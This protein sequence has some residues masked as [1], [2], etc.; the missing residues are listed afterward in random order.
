MLFT[1]DPA[2]TRERL[3]HAAHVPGSSEI[4]VPRE[5]LNVR[6]IPLP[7]TAKVNYVGLKE[8]AYRA[9]AAASGA[10]QAGEKQTGRFSRAD[11]YSIHDVP[12]RRMHDHA[13]NHSSATLHQPI[14]AETASRTGVTAC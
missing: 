13:G 10:G 14:P 1:T 7:G 8:D 11:R 2:L 12:S 3:Q 4:S 6:E 5:I 9:P